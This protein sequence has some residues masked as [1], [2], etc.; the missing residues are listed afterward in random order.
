MT[1]AD[2]RLSRLLAGVR[3]HGLWVLALAAPMGF[4]RVTGMVGP[5]EIVLAV[6]CGAAIVEIA[7]RRRRA[8]EARVCPAAALWVAA[9]LASAVAAA[10]DASLGAAFTEI[11]QLVE[12]LLVAYGWTYSAAD[13]HTG[14]ERAITGLAAAVSIHVLVACWQ[15]LAGVHVFQVSGLF[16]HR[17]T[18][19]AAVAVAVPL[20]VA[21]GLGGARRVSVRV[22]LLT[23]AAL[24]IL[25]LTSAAALA[26]A[27]AGVLVAS[28]AVDTRRGLAACAGLVV[29]LV[30]IQPFALPRVRAAQVRSAALFPADA[31]G[32]SSASARARRLQA[33]LNAVAENPALGVG[34]G[35]FQR[36][37]SEYYAPPYEKLHGSSADI[38]TYD[39]RFD[40]PGT[41]SLFEVAAVE[42]G[43][44]GLVAATAFFAAAIA[45]AARGCA[46]DRTGLAAGALGAACA[47]ACAGLALSIL[48]RG[49]AITVVVVLVL[50]RRSGEDGVG[51]GERPQRADAV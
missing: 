21:A 39:V 30:A 23:C 40:E 18:Y 15:V 37:I 25:T 22:W 42:T 14:R 32:R 50:G 49:I 16:A 45:R 4:V 6:L 3:R 28:F 35:Q 11:A 47:A 26:A 41:Q 46:G 34:V 1:D 36:R 7:T 5:V 48:T 51:G 44:L 9:A 13:D 33:A 29:L 31:S 2:D 20:F 17:N 19:G 43:L 8:R 27:V 12:V 10:P 38:D 24:G